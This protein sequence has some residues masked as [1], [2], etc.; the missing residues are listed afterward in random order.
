MAVCTH[1]SRN[2]GICRLPVPH[3]AHAAG[4]ARLGRCE[5]QKLAESSRVESSWC[6]RSADWALDP[7]FFEDPE[8]SSK[9][10]GHSTA[11]PCE[12][13]GSFIFGAAACVTRL[14]KRGGGHVAWLGPATGSL[15]LS[16]CDRHPRRQ[17]CSECYA[18]VASRS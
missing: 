16:H 1:L 7:P 17:T 2:K 14:R 18:Q 8:W 12:P 11:W 9:P 6:V 15:Q 13:A 10:R 4:Q 3:C 5:M